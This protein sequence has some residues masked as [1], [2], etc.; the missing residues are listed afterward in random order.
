M[1]RRSGQNISSGEVEATLRAH[2]A[3]GEV[4]VIPVADEL[5]DEEVYAC[6]V[7]VPEYAENPELADTLVRFCL[8]RLAYFKVPGWVAFFPGL[9]TT[10]SQKLR[11]SAIFG[12]KDPRAHP[13]AVDLRMI[14]QTRGKVAPAVAVS[15]D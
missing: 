1:V 15:P 8:E 5:R 13:N 3:V 12:E 9:P 2:P 10:Y 7:L 4:A 11:K 6:V 14:K